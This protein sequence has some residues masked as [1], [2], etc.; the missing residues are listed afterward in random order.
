MSGL[1]GRPW[2]AILDNTKVPCDRRLFMTATPRLW[3]VKETD[4]LRAAAA[5]IESAELIASMDDEALFGPVAHDYPPRNRDLRR[6]HRP[7]PD[8]VPYTRTSSRSA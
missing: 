8:P 6:G 1:A 2:A 7:L 4:R 5:G 3:A